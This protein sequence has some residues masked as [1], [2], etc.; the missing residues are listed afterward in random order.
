[1]SRTVH[2]SPTPRL[3]A[4]MGVSLALCL[5]PATVVAAAPSP[6][7]DTDP[8]R[9]VVEN[10]VMASVFTDRSTWIRQELWV[11]TEF[12]SDGDGVLDRM[13]VDVTR[14]GET[15]DGLD[16]PV[17]YETSP[18]YAGGNPVEN[19]SVDHEL[20]QP[21]EGPPPYV[22][23]AARSTSPV[24]STSHV[25]TWVPRGFA[26]VHSESPGTGLSTGCPS[27]GAANESLAPK[28]VIDWLNGRARGFTSLEGDEEVTADWSTGKVGMTGTS[29]NGTLPIGV[30]TTGV[31]G[32]E[33]IV[34]VAAISDWYDYYRANGL[35]VAP[36]GYQGE[37]ADILAA[38]VHTRPDR[39]VCAEQIEAMQTAQDRATGDR[40]DFWDERDYLADVG[41]ISAATL[42]AHGLADWNVK[43]SQATNL[44]SELQDRDVPSQLYLHQG[45]HGGP[46]PDLMMNRWF[47]RY[48]YGVE[49]GVEQDPPAWVAR[50]G[51]PRLEP[52]PYASWPVP[53]SRG[54][55]LGMAGDGAHEGQLQIF[56]RADDVQTVTDDATVR[57]LQ[58]A[59]ATS[60]E[61]R[62]LFRSRPLVQP[63]H[64]SGEPEVTITLSTDRPAVNLS[65]AIVATAADGTHQ[66]VTRGFA[67][68]QNHADLRGVGAPLRPG[69]Q[70]EVSF[71]YE[72][73]DRVVPAGSTLSVMFY[74]SD[75]DYTI[76]PA[77][78]S[79]LQI[80]LGRTVST[81]PVVGG[82]LALAVATDD[83]PAYT[84][85]LVDRADAQG[86][87]N[88]RDRV[89]LTRSLDR[90]LTFAAEGKAYPALRHLE[91]FVRAAGGIPD[92]V[93]RQDLLDAAAELR[94][95]IE[96]GEL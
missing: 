84:V 62:L 79:R 86:A 49:N 93:V 2:R 34:P 77:P 69:E 22:D 41:N 74:S 5:A 52:T 58:L 96:E 21:P 89:R 78:G 80:D 30:A 70:V 37:D 48:L 20:G 14:P 3:A 51:V 67:D 88:E 66:I 83:V 31:A 90:A 68:P 13:H 11:E 4:G 54:V 19:W 82:P 38:Y 33:A 32:L 1:M 59:S 73:I 94:A 16:V 53:G 18:Y 6:A 24:I 9:P 44:W 87:L 26:V 47:S 7:P 46:P 76:R 25:N 95:M 50:E 85:A 43:A 45:G 72:P 60:S 27:T 10:G 57:A 8:L 39:S 63:V 56:A 36:G 17:I 92:P 71:A 64:L 65:T 81:L 35:V 23:R 15:E 28:A 40:N 61:H 29:Y 12:D 42:I 91:E 75:H 55:D